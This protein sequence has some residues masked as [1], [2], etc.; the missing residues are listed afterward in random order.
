MCLD[1]IKRTEVLTEDL[2]VK[3]IVVR[4]YGSYSSGV[5]HGRDSLIDLHELNVDESDYL[6]HTDDNDSYKAGFHFYTNIELSSDLYYF[7]VVDYRDEPSW[8]GHNE[9]GVCIICRIPAGT[10]VTFGILAGDIVIVSPCF[11]FVKEEE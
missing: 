10:T 1:K 9:R 8:K 7:Y 3:K 6:I 4:K 11:Y 5:Y 2:L